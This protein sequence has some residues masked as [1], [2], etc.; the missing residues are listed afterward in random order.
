MSDKTY[1]KPPWI[2]TG[3]RTRAMRSAKKQKKE[4]EEH[5]TA[6]EASF[7]GRMT[8]QHSR[9]GTHG[10]HGVRRDG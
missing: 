2:K 1:N 8:K 9:S 7:R 4:A 5:G 6:R 10:V 3:R